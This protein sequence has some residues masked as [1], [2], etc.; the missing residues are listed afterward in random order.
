MVE[1]KSLSYNEI[2]VAEFIADWLLSKGVDSTFDIYNPADYLDNSESYPDTA[3]VYVDIGKGTKTLL[4]YAHMD[5][6]NGPEQLFL[7]RLMNGYLVGRGASDMKSSVAGLMLAAVECQTTIEASDKHVLFAFIADEETSGTGARHHTK[8]LK[9]E[10]IVEEKLWCILAEPTDGFNYVD[11]GGRGY[12]FLDIEGKLSSVVSA[13]RDLLD[14][15][16]TLIKHYPS[17]DKRFGR[18]SMS[19]TTFTTGHF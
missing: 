18:P 12:I 2:S 15:R 14:T 3:N 19:L 5:V 11:I 6:V 4:L 17:N 9:A 16:E 13:L 1:L 7:P 8:R 10:N